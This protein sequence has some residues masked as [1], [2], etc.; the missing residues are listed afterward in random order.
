MALKTEEMRLRLKAMECI[1]LLF[2]FSILMSGCIADGST[3]VGDGF[4]PEEKVIF[5]E[6]WAYDDQSGIVKS[7]FLFRIGNTA[8]LLE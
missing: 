8:Y 1:G 6:K 7:T 3:E 5:E 2:L 4:C